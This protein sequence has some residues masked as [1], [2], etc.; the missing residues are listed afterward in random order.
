LKGKS[1]KDMLLKRSD[2]ETYKAQRAA[3]DMAEN[4]AREAKWAA[5]RNTL[6]EDGTG[7]SSKSEGRFKES[8]ELFS[9]RDSA[10]ISVGE[11][12]RRDKKKFST[13]FES[14][15]TKRSKTGRSYEPAGAV[16]GESGKSKQLTQA[17]PQ[18][19]SLKVKQVDD[20]ALRLL[21]MVRSGN[22]KKAVEKKIENEMHAKVKI[23]DCVEGK[24]KDE[25][26]DIFGSLGDD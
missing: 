26:D 19:K 17:K 20:N 25:I 14:A 9:G 13:G 11:I 23:N 24:D 3:E 6:Q 2:P 16:F 7:K 18:R 22:H 1:H 8:S 15:E 5:K 12:G 10:N 21:A 4:A